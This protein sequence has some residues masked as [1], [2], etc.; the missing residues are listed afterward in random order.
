MNF[1]ANKRKEYLTQLENETF[2]LVVI[3]GG[4]TGA[5]IALDA[6]TR[7]L[8]VA[9]IEKSDFAFGTSSRSTKLIH[10]GLRYLKQLE[11]GIVME[12][13]RERAIL[14]KNAP[15]IVQ[16]E[17]MLLPIIKKGSLGKKSTSLGLFVY[18][19]L[20]GVKRKERRYMLNAKQTYEQ[21]PLLNK[22][23]L[24]GGGMYVEYRSDDARLTIE[25]IK[26]AVEKGALAV[27][28]VQSNGF[29]LN[30]QKQ[31]S[32]VIACDILTKKIINIKTK[33]VINAAGPWVDSMRKID[34]SLKGKRLHLTKGVHIVVPKSK[35]PIQHSTYFDVKDGRMI[36]AIPRGNI[37]Y[38]GTTDTTYKADKDFPFANIKDV[39]YILDAT[40]Y[41]FPSVQLTTDDVVSSWAGLRPLIHEDGKSPS[42]LSRKDEIFISNSNLIS[43]AGGKLTG[44]RKMAERSLNVVCKQLSKEE[45]RRIDRCSTDKIQLSGGK[46]ENK[47]LKEYS[48]QL[49]TQYKAFNVDEVLALVEKYGSNT[50]TILEYAI[51]KFNHDLLLAETYYAIHHENT[52]SISDFFIRRTGRLYFERDTL[53]NIIDKV[54]EFITTELQHDKETANYF[55]DEFKKEYEGVINFKNN[56]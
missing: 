30:A 19:T 35:M 11:F 47:S 8:K 17:K 55:Y 48:R 33:K 46:L 15:H 3:G 44:F 24:V 10:G 29:K 49:Q 32:E 13:G 12:V 36:F 38:I 2:D 40:N 52:N 34:N 14:Y 41:M 16:P 23:I 6:I 50:S 43:I 7:G 22:D 37:V 9:L 45:N 21:Q 20:A 27:N 25:V 18:D 26:T 54:H 56:N 51:Q 28:Y 5:G 39:Q 53:K 42:D 31:I 4:I 1:S